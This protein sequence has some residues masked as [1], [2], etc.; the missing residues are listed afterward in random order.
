[1]PDAS[2][3]TTYLFT[4]IE[5]STRL[6][7]REPERMRDALACHDR[8]SRAEVERHGG[9]VVKSTGDGIHAVFADPLAAVRASVALQLALA[10]ESATN[11][12][13]LRIRCGLH[14]G[15]GHRRDDDFFGNAVNRAARIMS[16]AHGG[17][18]LL[19][20]AVATLVAGRLPPDTTL[21]D[22]G[23]VRLRDLSRPER[24][25]QVAHPRLRATFPA[26]RSLEATPN[27][28]PQQLT[29]F[30]GRQHEVATVC[31]L[32]RDTR[33]LTLV[34]GG[35][36]GKTRLSL[37]V[38]AQMLGDY[39]D[40]AWFIE[41][42]PVSD[43][44]MVAQAVASVLG[45]KEEPGRPV[46]AALAK[47]AAERRFL[48]VLD[49]CEHLT[50]AC[51]E[52]AQAMLESG[53]GV[54]ILASSRE[55]L[56]IA[57]ERTYPL[58]PLVVPSP[59]AQVRAD[60][61]APFAAVQLFADRAAAAQSSFA[62]TDANAAAVAEICRRLDG[63]PLALELAAA[64]LRS[65]SV[66]RIAER[67][68]DRFR[69][70]T[71]GA[72]T[73][74]PRQQTLR[75]LI[76]WSYDLLD[77]PER[78]LFRRLAVFPGGFT[79]EAAEKI[80]AG[81]GLAE[82]DVLDLL[83]RLVEKSL[84]SLDAEGD[85]YRMLETVRQYAREKLDESG[86]TAG[87]RTRH[88]HFFLALAESATWFGPGQREWL[89]RFDAERENLFAAHAWC[90]QADDGGSLGLRLVRAIRFYCLHRG[91][92]ALGAAA[93]VDALR[94]PGA[95]TRNV[96]RSQAL[97]SAGVFASNMGRHAEALGYLQESLAIA[98][99]LG[100]QARIAITLQPLGGTY[101]ALG[102]MEEARACLEE[103]LA[104]AQSNGNPREIAAA[105]SWLVQ[106]RRVEGDYDSALP[107]CNDCL[108]IVRGLGDSG[109]VTTSLINLAMIETMRGNLAG[110][111]D[112]IADALPV[113]INGGSRFLGQCLLTSVAGL[114]AAEGDWTAAARF[115]GAAECEAA[116]A[117]ITRDP[118]DEGFVAALMA[119]ARAQMGSAPFAAATADGRAIDYATA[120]A[121]TRDWLARE[122]RNASD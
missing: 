97:S 28:L 105:L 25:F 1:M 60:V 86:D 41:L 62:I 79:L 3:V 113:V 19:S 27:N 78:V 31:R 94:R 117:G 47:F 96:A 26:L 21:L 110:A 44:R 76:D 48:I 88:L 98:R 87:T 116:L 72:R 71:G 32:L 42:A 70:L 56:N 77:A 40:G 12:V 37:Q 15:A 91:L 16:V 22:L 114:A 112:A 24:V 95:Q 75:A 57:G 54:R 8:L 36:L 61:I 2:A 10:D 83:G 109:G 120:L 102:E 46:I 9:S 92:L 34:G 18:V 82:D 111:R 29:S 59:G 74:L 93:I 7:E 11:G 118:A 65:M 66:E 39:P 52:F 33:H 108:A 4:D 85:H 43:P 14:A 35:G 5:G 80:G 115:F 73:A 103:A 89:A 17:Q 45:V 100:D 107:L 58:A 99:E 81:D 122:G 84:V 55:A 20:S 69:L 49:N 119:R 90:D 30:I 104:L 67:L 53:P 51:A 13:A 101:L 6:W 121:D 23:S 106:L 68:S 63:I 38:A 50:Q 64:R